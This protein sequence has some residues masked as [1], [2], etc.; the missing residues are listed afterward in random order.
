M[1]N[2]AF[3][4]TVISCRYCIFDLLTFAATDK[5]A[6]LIGNCNYK[7]QPLKCSRNDVEAVT[8]KLRQMNF[9]TISLVDLTLSQMAKAADYFCSLLDNGMYAVFYYSG[10]GVENQHNNRTYLMPIDASEPV[11]FDQ[12]MNV[13]DITEKMQAKQSKV[14]MILDCCR[15]K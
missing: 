13:D 10:H 8:K 7:G 5:M 3:P 15:I 11:K 4:F 14:I 6:L 9:K 1:V 12:C 2:F